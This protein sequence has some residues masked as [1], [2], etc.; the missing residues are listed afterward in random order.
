MGFA[1]VGQQGNSQDEGLSGSTT[2][3]GLL[4]TVRENW[5]VFLFYKRPVVA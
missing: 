2:P 1:A 5:N 3:V 4:P